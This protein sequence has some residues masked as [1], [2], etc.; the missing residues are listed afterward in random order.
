MNIYCIYLTIYLGKLL[1]PFYIGSAKITS[2]EKGYHG[3]VS[4][5]T[6]KDIWRQE[7]KNNPQLFYTIIITDQFA[8]NVKDKLILEE[9]W[10]RIFSAV[11]SK[12]FLNMSY[13]NYRFIGNSDSAKQS[14]ITRRKNNN[15]NVSDDHREALRH[16]N[17]GKRVWN[18][19]VKMVRSTDSPGPEWKLGFIDRVKQNIS[20]SQKNKKPITDK[21]REKLRISSTGRLHSNKTKQLLRE[22]ST[23]TIKSP[24]S[25]AKMSKNMKGRIPYNKGIKTGKTSATAKR[26][27]FR[28]LDGIQFEYQSVRQGCIANNLPTSK[29]CDVSN[30]KLLS[31]KGWTVEIITEDQI[32]RQKGKK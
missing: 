19:D 28:N 3:S 2:I 8:D 4:S 16:N 15:Y 24:E 26:C 32:F 29:M 27:I 21:T 13:A 7:I 11:R 22:K 12:L 10:Q 14:V 17:L 1:P 6:Y 20:N 31:Y 23:G 30:G 18:N 5:K 25:R 9:K